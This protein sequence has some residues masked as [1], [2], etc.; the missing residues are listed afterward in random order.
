[1]ATVTLDERIRKLAYEMLDVARAMDAAN[2]D[3]AGD[4]KETSFQMR[5]IGVLLIGYAPQP[6]PP[7]NDDKI[8]VRGDMFKAPFPP[9]ASAAHEEMLKT[10]DRF[11]AL[12]VSHGDVN[13]INDGRN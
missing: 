7:V 8:K 1:M 2:G 10:L 6:L 11:D 9:H 5:R 13:S 4:V 3:R 12:D